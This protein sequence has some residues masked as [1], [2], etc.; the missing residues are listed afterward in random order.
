MC[1]PQSRWFNFWKEG[2]QQ[3]ALIYGIKYRW[4]VLILCCEGGWGRGQYYHQ[5][6]KT[7][8][9]F[10]IMN[11]GT[12][13]LDEQQSKSW[14]GVLRGR[15]CFFLHIWNLNSSFVAILRS[16]SQQLLFVAVS[17]NKTH[18]HTTGVDLLPSTCIVGIIKAHCGTTIRQPV[19]SNWIE[20]FLLLIFL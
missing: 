17:C 7:L 6:C 8:C 5:E 20:L 16:T 18:T 12:W 15:S 1:L 13:F 4:F 2:L 19:Y 10:I 11:H 9:A 14:G 3:S